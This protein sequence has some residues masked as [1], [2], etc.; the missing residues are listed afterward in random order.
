MDFLL[1]DGALKNLP[2]VVHARVDGD[3]LICTDVRG[4]VRAVF[5]RGEVVAWGNRPHLNNERYGVLEFLDLAKG[6]PAV[7][8]PDHPAAYIE[9]LRSIRR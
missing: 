9:E 5:K 6:G 3:R 1:A 8:L 2:T 7:P 4:F